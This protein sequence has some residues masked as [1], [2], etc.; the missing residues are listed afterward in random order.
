MKWL[1][2]TLSLTGELAEAAAEVIPRYTPNSIAMQYPL[3]GD[4]IDPQAEV[5]LRAYLEDG[6]DVEQTRQAIEADLWHLSKIE[7]FD[8]PSF[9]WIEGD[10]WEDAWKDRYQPI[11]I[12]ERLLIQPA[13]L[14]IEDPDRIPILIDPGMAF[15]TGT[16]PSTQLC[17][18]ALEK[19]LQPGQRVVDL[20]C[21]SGILAIAAAKLGASRVLALDIDE[22]AVRYS[23]KN[24]KANSLDQ[25]IIVA[26]GSL[27]YLQG[28]HEFAETGFEL[29]LA[30][31]LARVLLD[32]L[33]GGLAN[34]LPADGI[35][36]LSGILDHQ[37]EELVQVGSSQDLEH[38]ETGEIQEWR[39]LVFKRKSPR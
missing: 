15:G 39:S 33:Q 4:R 11:Q 22:A 35:L 30:N 9:N 37:A 13:W 5:V 17:L 28:D 19:Y 36:V 6:R 12:G 24:I 38:L 1:E 18:L 32:L 16:H 14:P 8:P 34:T 2:I 27:E 21:G 29:L 7:P 26:Q 23:Q 31:I 10:R 20:G 3:E 25:E